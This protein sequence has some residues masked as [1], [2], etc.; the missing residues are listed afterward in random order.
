[1][2]ETDII[3]EAYVGSGNR[4]AL[5]ALAE[6]M[7]A[8]GDDAADPAKWAQI[9]Q[10]LATLSAAADADRPS[11]VTA[12]TGAGDAGSPGPGSPGLGAPDLDARDLDARD[13]GGP[14]A[15]GLAPSELD[16]DIG[17]AL[18]AAERYSVEPVDD[19]GDT[20]LG[21]SMHEMDPADADEMQQ[22]VADLDL[23]LEALQAFGQTDEHMPWDDVAP[24]A[25][26]A[27]D[28][29]DAPDAEAVVPDPSDDWAFTRAPGESA[30]WDES[31][32]KMDLARAYIEMDDPEAARSIL[33]EVI[34]E[35]SAA[36]QAEAKS[37]IEALG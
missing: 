6:Q 7:C 10:S 22:N 17:A 33:E 24:P 16:L 23:D 18:G 8:A 5:M 15:V 11:G 32:T 12:P 19:S 21:F 31:A 3:P 37:L 4:Q 1:M 36:Q 27:P 2:Q 26:N 28:A 9:S 30:P 20:G 13:Q 14:A 35:G 25:P 29:P 34:L